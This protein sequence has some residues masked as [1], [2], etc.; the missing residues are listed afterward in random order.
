MHSNAN[1]IN[2]V[3]EHLATFS[4]SIPAPITPKTAIQRLFTLEKTAGIWTQQMI[5]KITGKC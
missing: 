2:Y 4:T 5:L 3:V 1:D